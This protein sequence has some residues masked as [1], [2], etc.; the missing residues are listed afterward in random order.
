M[1]TG[2]RAKPRK[3]TYGD[4]D[5]HSGLAV[6][7]HRQH[8]VIPADSAGILRQAWLIRPKALT[9]RASLPR[10]LVMCH[11][12]GTF[13]TTNDYP[14]SAHNAQGDRRI[15][16]GQVTAYRIGRVQ[17]QVST[18][19]GKAKGAAGRGADAGHSVSLK[20]ALEFRILPQRIDAAQLRRTS[21][22]GYRKSCRDHALPNV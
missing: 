21:V 10:S 5:D 13:M 12:L 9:I 22:R 16:G 6:A 8:G 1:T 7:A 18:V 2:S 11:S 15:A 20:A 14:R 4:R 3:P 17:P 19:A